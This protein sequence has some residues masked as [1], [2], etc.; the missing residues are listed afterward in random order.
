MIYA[1]S[2]PTTS[3]SDYRA[4]NVMS[5]DLYINGKRVGTAT[6]VQMPEFHHTEK[7]S[8]QCSLSELNGLSVTGTLSGFELAKAEDNTPDKLVMRAIIEAQNTNKKVSAIKMRP[9]FYHNFYAQFKDQLSFTCDTAQK[10]MFWG[11]AVEVDER[12][13]K[14][15][16]LTTK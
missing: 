13:N 11:F 7:P 6:M 14:D 5:G 15:F 8:G 9:D 12:I 16:E 2:L 3:I 4:S 1:K 10:S